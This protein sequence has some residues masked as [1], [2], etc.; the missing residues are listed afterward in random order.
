[1]IMKLKYRCTFISGTL[2]Q[3]FDKFDK[4]NVLCKWNSQLQIASV[5][6]VDNA[7]LRHD[8]IFFGLKQS[9]KLY[10]FSS[11]TNLQVSKSC[12]EF[13]SSVM[14]IFR[15][16]QKLLCDTAHR[17]LENAFCKANIQ[18]VYNMTC[19]ILKSLFLVEYNW[20]IQLAHMLGSIQGCKIA[21]LH[22]LSYI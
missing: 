13:L 15:C 19:S 7:I 14:P 1:M 12:Y 8:N 18:P 9:T 21:S 2:A 5:I 6:K 22:S 10:L 3:H 4:I 17:S 20:H 11:S 16:R